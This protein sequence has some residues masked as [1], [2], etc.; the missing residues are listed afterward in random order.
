M[1]KNPKQRIG[2][3]DKSEIKRHP[4][5]KGLDWQKLYNRELTPPVAL[6]ME[7]DPENEELQYLKMVEKQK[8]RDSDYQNDNKTLNRVKQFTFI[9][10]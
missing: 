2:V 1:N 9:R 8:F 5:F 7:E 6:L 4:F 10:Q 3:T